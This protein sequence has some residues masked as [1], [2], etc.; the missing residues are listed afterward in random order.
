[1]IIEDKKRYDV[2]QHNKKILKGNIRR[3]KC[4][5][6]NYCSKIRPLWRELVCTFFAY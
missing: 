5:V 3:V 4:G 2:L 6:T 1:M